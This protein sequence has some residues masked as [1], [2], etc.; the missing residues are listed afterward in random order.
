MVFVPWSLIEMFFFSSKGLPFV[1][2][3]LPLSLKL[4][5]VKAFEDLLIEDDFLSTSA[6]STSASQRRMG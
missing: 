2:P 4:L 5:I 1:L 6:S 3:P